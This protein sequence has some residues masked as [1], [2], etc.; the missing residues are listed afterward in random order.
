MSL[1]NL[2]IGTWR[3]MSSRKSLFNRLLSL[4]VLMCVD[5]A[6]AQPSPYTLKT[7]REALLVG[8]GAVVT[9]LGHFLGS[10]VQPP[11]PEKLDMNGINAFDRLTVNMHYPGTAT[12]SDVTLFSCA[13][14]PLIPA[15]STGSGQTNREA[16]LMV[17]EAYLINEGITKLTKVLV[18]RA[19]PYAYHRPREIL[20]GDASQS[21]FSGHTSMAFAGAVAA[22]LLTQELHSGS[23][24][25]SA[26][27]SVS[28][29]LALT[30]GI[31][32]ITSGKH[33]PTDVLIGAL[34]GSLVSYLV[35]KL[36]Q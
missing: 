1:L 33:F 21:F 14:L 27:W 3:T 30:T 15:L 24:V 6:S 31:C 34:A 12:V 20:K 5:F 4:L 10:R 19:R 16:L 8:G 7:G 23:E 9:G 36:H 11:D 26:I 17:L 25:N 13:A 35:L 22:G 32:R 18:R 28:M 2:F 29:G